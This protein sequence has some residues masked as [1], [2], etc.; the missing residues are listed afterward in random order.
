MPSGAWV[1]SSCKL[2]KVKGRVTGIWTQRYRRRRASRANSYH[3]NY[4]H[5]SRQR[6]NG[7][8]HDNGINSSGHHYRSEDGCNN[9]KAVFYLSLAAVRLSD[10]DLTLTTPL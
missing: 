10:S 7:L 2:Y 8:G 3:R 5:D 4:R 9:K 6:S 1:I